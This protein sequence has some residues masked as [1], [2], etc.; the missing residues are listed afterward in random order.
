MVGA[1]EDSV[2]CGRMIVD[3]T[4]PTLRQGVLAGCDDAGC[5]EAGET[6][7]MYRRQPKRCRRFDGRE[8]SCFQEGQGDKGRAELPQ[9]GFGKRAF[10]GQREIADT[11]FLSRI[12]EAVLPDVPK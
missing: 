10:E 8:R 1:I 11:V 12:V 6:S 2:W 9:A 7:S 5:A 3:R 4:R